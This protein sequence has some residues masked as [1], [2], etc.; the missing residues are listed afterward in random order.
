MIRIGYDAKRL[1]NNFTGLGN[2]SR[3]L[4]QQLARYYP[5]HAYFLYTPNAKPHA[6]TRHFMRSPHFTVQRADSRWKSWWRSFGI[7]RD[8][9]HHQIRLYHGLSHEIPFGIRQTGIKS[10]VTIHDLIFKRYPAQY[11]SIDR[12]IYDIKFRYACQY[13]DKVI[14]ISK[15]TKDDIIRYY[16]I[17]PEKITVIYQTCQDRFK[18]SLSKR[19][20]ETVR[21]K[22]GL[23]KAYLL[24]VGSIIPRKNLLNTIKALQL[25]PESLRLPLIV[26]GNGQQYK[27][28]ILRYISDEGL[29]ALVRLVEVSFKDLPALYQSATLFVYPSFYEGFG[30]PVLEALY[31]RVPVLTSNTSSLPEAAGPGAML[32]DPAQPESIA[33]GIRE[34]LT[35]EVKYEKAI[36]AGLEHLLLFDSERLARQMMEL[37]SNVLK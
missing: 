29:Q 19:E 14:A 12:L 15:S 10:V 22:Y 7:K 31:S 23:P 35:H 1:F 13:A 9:R 25:L 32:V 6:E 30:I 17:T 5:E 20:L 3:T 27:R 21:R 2:Y 24:S 33:N 16:G 8:L 4:L 28:K 34:L 11:S 18:K 36:A 26:V 37:Y